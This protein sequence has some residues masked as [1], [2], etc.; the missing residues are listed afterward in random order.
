MITLVIAHHAAQAYGP[1]GGA[2][3][4]ANPIRSFL[5]GPFFA[6][7][8]TFFMGLLFLISGYFAAWSYE[9]KGAAT[10]LKGRFIR[11]GIPLLVFTGFVL[12]P[13]AYLFGIS[14]L[15]RQIPGVKKVL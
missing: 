4:I 15:V 14:H 7:N 2:W 3:P 8:A 9:R 5:L 1:T 13:I 6:V 12:G 11:L 10:F